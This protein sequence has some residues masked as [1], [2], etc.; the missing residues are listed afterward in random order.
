MASGQ[1]ED[2]R[3]FVRLLLEGCEGC[4]EG[5]GEIYEVGETTWG[6]GGGVCAELYEL[7][8]GVRVEVSRRIRGRLRRV[9]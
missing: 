2:L 1:S 7:G 4:E 3:A 9:W 5:L 8:F 6:L